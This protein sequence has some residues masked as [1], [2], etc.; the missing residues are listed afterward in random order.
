MR[1]TE[2]V[3]SSGSAITL[4]IA[5]T[6][7]LSCAEP[8]A[9]TALE[10]DLAVTEVVD[11]AI[12]GIGGRENL[13]GLVAFTLKAQRA[14]FMTG[15]GPIVGT[16]MLAFPLTNLQV[17]HDLAGQRFR[18]DMVREWA[19][20]GGGVDEF[21]GNELIIGQTGYAK[22]QDLFRVTSGDYEAMIPERVAAAIK[23]EALLNPH[24]LLKELMENPSLASLGHA[25]NP[26]GR[27]L[28]Q[29]QI[30]P[31]TLD[32]IRQSGKRKLIVT[33][34]WME[35]WGETRFFELMAEDVSVQPNW[36]DR[37]HDTP[38]TAK[39]HHRLIVQDPTHP[40]TLYVDAE[41]GRIDKLE[42]IEFD[43]VNGDVAL[44][45]I[46][47]D[48][49]SI[50]GVA[51]PTTINITLAGAPTLEVKRSDIVVNPTLD[52]SRLVAPDGVD[53]R[54]DDALADRGR[55]ISQTL[56]A[57]SRALG[58]SI[59]VGRPTIVATQLQPGIHLLGSEPFNLEAVY[60]MVV[61]QANG[62]VVMEPGMNPLKGEAVMDWV[63]EQFPGKA[64]THVIVSHWHND[65][66]AGMRP[67]IAKGA[68]VVG[69]DSAVD[70]YRALAERPV[71]KLVP[72]RLDL[73]PTAAEVVGVPADGSYR[74]DDATHSVVVYP[75]E[76][77]HTNDM[78]MATV[79]DEGF[80][81]SGDL[82]VSGIARLLRGS[83]VERMPGI[84]PFHSAVSLD[85][86]IDLHG[87]KVSKMVGS[88][89]PDLVDYEHLRT[90]I[91]D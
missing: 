5:A 56:M 26:V 64:V 84:R 70:F 51:F 32:R 48:W 59:K 77:G 38:V 29:Q 40:I 67:Y 55:R 28:S 62:I 22:E 36:L 15:Q 9:P 81:Y 42:T 85:K 89:D 79:G 39:T 12:T 2:R 31:I 4:A 90:Y 78:V 71:S 14:P 27:R 16:G 25:D 7:L 45:V 60:T 6:A 80:L 20:R 37:W 43:Y 91:A 46:Y 23:T 30:L 52:E 57:F 17:T 47:R 61:E 49:E 18:L 8:P 76:M 44:E 87:L 72:D 11:K 86:A 75:V 66:A 73:N 21:Q 54:H 35:Q 24:L 50:A 69:H 10:P 41:S 74:I 33:D 65:H 83:G 1:Q 3:R 34:S 13:S 82:Y 88:H 68:I 58:R 19:A 63:A 53:Y